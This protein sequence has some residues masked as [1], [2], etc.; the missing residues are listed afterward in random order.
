MPL[1]PPKKNNKKA[2]LI[3][4]LDNFFRILICL[5]DVCKI[6]IPSQIKYECRNYIPTNDLN[7]IELKTQQTLFNQ[8]IVTLDITSNTYT[9][10][11]KVS[12]PHTPTKINFNSQQQRG[13]QA[14]F[15]GRLEK[16]QRHGV[17]VLYLLAHD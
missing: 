1:P 12:H 6:H 10:A 14:S 9:K 8:Q 7:L 15:C 16:N 3:K 13:T 4:S 11:F 5:P 2:T 17:S